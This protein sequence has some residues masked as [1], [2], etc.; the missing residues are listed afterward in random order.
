LVFED[1][2]MAAGGG[3]GDADGKLLGV[4]QEEAA[5]EGPEGPP[6]WFPDSQG[7]DNLEHGH[8]VPAAGGADDNMGVGAVVRVRGGS[9]WVVAAVRV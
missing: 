8:D 5:Q 6:A 7:Q 1:A 4:A 9:A 2:E 3:H